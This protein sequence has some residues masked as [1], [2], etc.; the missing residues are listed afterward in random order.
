[1]TTHSSGNKNQLHSCIYMQAL[2]LYHH[3]LGTFRTAATDVSDEYD[4]MCVYAYL[5]VF[6]T[7]YIVAALASVYPAKQADGLYCVH[8]LCAAGLNKDQIP[9]KCP[10]EL[11][12]H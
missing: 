1:M 3:P 9:K 10:A 4:N 7:K 6:F 11:S 5:C 8:L 12:N 2:L